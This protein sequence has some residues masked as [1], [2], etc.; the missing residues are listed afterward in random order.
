VVPVL[1]AKSFEYGVLKIRSAPSIRTCRPTSSKTT[2][3]ST[4]PSSG[5]VPAW[6]ETSS[7]EPDA[8]TFSAPRTSTRNQ[9]WA[10][11]RITG[12]NSAWVS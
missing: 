12:R 2:E 4:M 11:Q 7:A 5:S 9:L 6:L 10:S 1:R 3:C 8:G